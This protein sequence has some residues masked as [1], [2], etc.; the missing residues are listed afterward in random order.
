MRE[1]VGV[2][3]VGVVGIEGDLSEVVEVGI[4]GLI[5][6]R[7]CY[8]RVVQERE[9]DFCDGGVVD[10]WSSDGVVSV[11][12]VLE[13]LCAGAFCEE[14]DEGVCVHNVVP[15]ESGDISLAMVDEWF[16]DGS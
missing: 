4:G 9:D 10:I 13:E 8:R 3:V 14:R 7:D 2:G 15:F 6:A 5:W 16:P 12:V 11:D 1:G